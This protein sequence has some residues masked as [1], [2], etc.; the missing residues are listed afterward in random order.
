LIISRTIREYE[1]IPFGGCQRSIPEWAAARL[2]RAASKSAL[3]GRSG[4]S[5]LNFGRKDLKARHVVG[6]VAA[7]GCVLEI[8]PKIDGL[9]RGQEEEGQVR[10]RLIHMIA[11]ALDLKV[12]SGHMAGLGIQRENLLEVLIGLFAAKLADAVRRGMPRRYVPCEGDLPA[13]RG[14]LNAV[15]QF[16]SLVANPARLAC[17]Y[18]SLSSDLLLNQAMKAA[19]TLLLKVSR[20]AANR[21]LLS[22]LAFDYADISVVPAR[23]IR[24]KEIG[25]DRTN[26]RWREL[27]DLARLLLGGQHQTTSHGAD[28]GFSLLFEMHVLFE[29]YVARLL[30]RALAGSGHRVVSQGGFRYCLFEEDGRGRFQTRPDILVKKGDEIL[31]VIDTKWKRIA[32]RIDDPKQGVSQADI[33]QMMA[34]GRI[35]SCPELMLIY[36]HHEGLTTAGR[37]CSLS[38][39]GSRDRLTTATVDLAPGDKATAAALGSLVAEQLGRHH[40]AGALQAA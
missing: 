3:A 7:E 22:Q 10:R 2:A 29:S 23:E 5:V 33:Y 14:R 4:S 20:N 38:V 34:Y 37:T 39:S 21:R 27:L 31:L 15:R 16:T 32:P 13:L 8:L 26:A 19:V 30:S 25:L 28:R 35:Y 9:G 24:W 18:D 11:L 36:P 40:H 17:R 6:V 12:D 1:A